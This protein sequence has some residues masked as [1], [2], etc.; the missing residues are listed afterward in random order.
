MGAPRPSRPHLEAAGQEAGISGG[1]Q[2]TLPG[3][4]RANWPVTPLPYSLSRSTTT[5]L[6]H[7]TVVKYG[8]Q[9]L[10]PHR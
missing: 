8:V 4:G 9:K 3:S 7:A 5:S 2:A 6:F 10:S 1:S